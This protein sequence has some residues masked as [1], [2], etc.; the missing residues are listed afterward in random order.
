MFA[1]R[2]SGCV[3]FLYESTARL[4]RGNRAHSVTL[5]FFSGGISKN[6]RHLWI[7]TC[8]RIRLRSTLTSYRVAFEDT[9]CLLPGGRNGPKQKLIHLMS[10][11]TAF[12]DITHASG[13]RLPHQ[14]DV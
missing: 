1:D 3:V 6:D 12:K 10:T 9:L 13:G 7:D 4:P 14:S 8:T 11:Q 5:Q 2:D